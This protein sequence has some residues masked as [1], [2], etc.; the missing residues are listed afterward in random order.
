MRQLA[1]FKKS[2]RGRPK[3]DDAGV[4]HLRRAVLNPRV[5]L[6]VT[7]RVRRG[8]R[9]LRHGVC[10]K[11]IRKSFARGN[12]RFGLRLVH[13]AVLGNHMHFIAEAEGKE[14]LARGMQG[15]EIRIAKA[16]NRVMQRRGRVFSDRYHARMLR[17]PTE[18]RRAV[19][20]VLR[21]HEHHFGPGEQGPS[22]RWCPQE[23]ATAVTWLLRANDPSG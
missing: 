2:K 20:Y 11:A 14:S 19:E 1:L 7:V 5:P 22:S 17:T 23:M 12:G 4:S 10:L 6:H 3:K 9:D 21:N 8:V 15:L 13:F 16:L 18:V